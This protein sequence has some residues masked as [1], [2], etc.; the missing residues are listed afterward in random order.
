MAR[1]KVSLLP[2]FGC[3]FDFGKAGTVAPFY[4]ENGVAKSGHT[5]R[6]DW[7][8]DTLSESQITKVI[9]KGFPIKD[10]NVVSI[11]T[12]DHRDQIH[13]IFLGEVNEGAALLWK[14]LVF[15]CAGSF[16][17][18]LAFLRHVNPS[19]SYQDDEALNNL[20][21][22]FS[23]KTSFGEEKCN[24]LF[25]SDRNVIVVRGIIDDSVLE[26]PVSYPELK[27]DY[28][29]L[30]EVVTLFLKPVNSRLTDEEW[31]RKADR[32]RDAAEKYKHV[33]LG[34][35]AEKSADPI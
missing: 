5:T 19:L 13:L 16:F 29:D 28:K 8:D 11:T 31:E 23:Y 17:G 9:P 20:E 6:G 15:L 27:D 32:I 22:F 2:R 4:M 7:I 26:E 25:D 18:K 3:A 35:L 14:T 21:N 10:G 12:I 33:D 24:M 34:S 30:K 1:Q